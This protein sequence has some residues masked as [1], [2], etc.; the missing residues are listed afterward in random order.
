[1][2]K[3]IS[4]NRVY[5]WCLG[6]SVLF[7][8]LGRGLQHLF[9]DAPYRALLWDQALL[10]KPL[11]WL[12]IYWQ[13]FV[14]NLG[15]ETVISQF[16]I[17][18]GI[19]AISTGLFSV[20]VLIR[21]NTPQKALNVL[22]VLLKIATA[23]LI[24]L[25]FLY[26]KSTG[27]RVGQFI[28]YASQ[29]LSPIALVWLLQGKMRHLEKFFPLAISLTFL[30]HGLYAI[31]YYP[32]PGHFIDMTI[33]ILGTSEQMARNLLRVAGALD[34]LAAILIFLPRA[35]VPV[36]YFC[37]AWGT[38]TAFARVAAGLDFSQLWNS[39]FYYLPS[40]IYRLPHGLIPLAYLFFLSHKKPAASA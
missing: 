17:A 31:G 19:F 33:A 6:L 27:Y 11:S 14:E 26:S 37:I 24:L 2:L 28:E 25:A 13:S 10:E 12:G 29:F 4:H 15:A 39:I 16:S 38:V 23:W 18:L 7:V 8:L 21:D 5:T 3:I 32:Q 9:W 30:G 1:M 22:F 20:A 40:T 35:K 34:I 36:L